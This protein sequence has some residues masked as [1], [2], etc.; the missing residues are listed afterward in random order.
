MSSIVYSGHRWSLLSRRPHYGDEIVRKFET[1]PGL[2]R[3]SARKLLFDAIGVGEALLLP[4]ASEAEQ[5]AAEATARKLLQF[6]QNL[7]TQD[8]LQG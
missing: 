5:E 3:D 2:R 8:N 7:G 1:E 4:D 6:L